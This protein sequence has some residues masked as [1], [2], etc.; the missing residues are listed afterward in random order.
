MQLSAAYINFSDRSGSMKHWFKTRAP[1]FKVHMDHFD[2]NNIFNSWRFCLFLATID[3]NSSINDQ[4]KLYQLF[5]HSKNIVWLNT[6]KDSEFLCPPSLTFPHI[7]F[8]SDIKDD[9]FCK[10]SKYLV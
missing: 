1:T 7:P 8:D 2:P 6:N 9:I 5:F 4:Q 10:T 3:M